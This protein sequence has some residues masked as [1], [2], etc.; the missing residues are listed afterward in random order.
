MPLWGYC[1]VVEGKKNNVPKPL[2]SVV[3][4]LLYNKGQ[5]ILIDSAN[6]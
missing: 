3:D 1:M 6:S 5:V 2:S 4:E